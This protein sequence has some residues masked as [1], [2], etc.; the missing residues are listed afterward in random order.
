MLYCIGRGEEGVLTFEPHKSHLLPLWRF[1]TPEIARDSSKKLW[2]ECLRADKERDFVWV[3]M[4]RK[5]EQM[6][7]TRA[8]RYAR[9]PGG[10]KYDKE[11]GNLLPTSTDHP[12]AQEKLESLAG[13]CVVWERCKTHEGYGRRREEW[14]R[15]R[16]EWE[17]GRKELRRGMG[18][19]RGVV[20][21]EEEE[22][23]EKPAPKRRQRTQ[24]VK[25]EEE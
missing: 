24:R 22:E 11:M 9:C 3:D 12:G 17:K 21:V 25:D 4:V 10:H 20:K 18:G 7:M 1:K 2:G 19:E 13:F 5:F 14:E 16:K 23:E 6:G 8:T 15:E